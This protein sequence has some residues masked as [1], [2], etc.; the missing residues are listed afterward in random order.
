MNFKEEDSKFNIQKMVYKFILRE[1]EKN[2]GIPFYVS[3]GKKSRDFNMDSFDL[4]KM[5]VEVVKPCLY[6]I[7]P[8]NDDCEAA[9]ETPVVPEIRNKNSLQVKRFIDTDVVDNYCDMV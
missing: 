3:D 1:K 6:V 5:K 7:V 9:I 4:S 2:T 8:I